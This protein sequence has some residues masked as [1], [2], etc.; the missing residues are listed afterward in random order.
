MFGNTFSQSSPLFGTW[1]P[2]ITPVANITSVV[3]GNWN[4][5]IIGNQL[6][7]NGYALVTPTAAG[8]QSSFYHSLPG[9]ANGGL[10]TNTEQLNT[11]GTSPLYNLIISGQPRIGAFQA[12]QVFISP[13]AG[14]GMF[15]RFSGGCIIP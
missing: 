4:Y 1:L 8:I 13:V 12:W 10:F 3:P 6:L 9:I 2:T 15:C 7:I 5:I 11:N 14:V